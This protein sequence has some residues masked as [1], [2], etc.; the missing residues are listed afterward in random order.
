MI[1]T[2]I[3][4]KY[5][6]KWENEIEYGYNSP[7]TRCKRRYSDNYENATEI[8]NNEIEE[9]DDLDFENLDIDMED[10]K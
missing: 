5:N 3:G 1:D 6:G 9:E 8:K 2:C 10:I 4:C 7:C